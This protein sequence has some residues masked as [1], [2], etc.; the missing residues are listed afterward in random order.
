MIY[1]KMSEVIIMCGCCK[2]KI[3]EQGSP[4]IQSKRTI[5]VQNE[6]ENPE[7]M[8]CVNCGQKIPK[9]TII[10]HSCGKVL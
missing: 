7:S 5:D 8:Y 1:H 3:R 2:P 10:C 4:Q 6:P 9:G